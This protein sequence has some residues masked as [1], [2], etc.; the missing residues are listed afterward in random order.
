MHLL[1]YN[2][3]GIARFMAREGLRD[4]V[5]HRQGQEIP[6]GIQCIDTA[7]K[8]ARMDYQVLKSDLF[9]DVNGERVKVDGKCLVYRDEDGKQLGVNGSDFR[10]IQPREVFECV[11]EFIQ[12]GEL[13]IDTM[14]TMKE[15]K[16]IFM[17]L[18]IESDPLE[19]VPGEVLERHIMALDGYDGNTP[20]T[21]ASVATTPVCNNTVRA[22]IAEAQNRGDGLIRSRHTKN[23]LS[24]PRKDVMR[25][26]LGIAKHQ[27][28][29]FAEFGRSL[30]AIKMSDKA[31]QEFYSAIV[32]GDKAATDPSEWTSQQRRKVA[33]MMCCYKE[34]DGQVN[35]ATPIDARNGTAWGAFNGVTAW[36]NHLNT[37]RKGE[38]ERAHNVLFGTGDVV[39]SK[40]AQLLVRQYALAA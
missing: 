22:A 40:A 33:E 37:I 23:A 31:V 15:G 11:Q 26:A 28:E 18:S 20:L 13:T 14:G 38:T 27:F 9:A 35:S 4:K 36:T 25:R 12:G 16:Q 3:E 8:A 5:W 39:N 1:D 19:I 29:A 21:F 34:G 24:T 32:M 6:D 17:S 30:A 7:L 10:V 2:E